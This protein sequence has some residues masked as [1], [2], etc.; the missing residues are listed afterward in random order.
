MLRPLFLENSLRVVLFVRLSSWEIF[1]LIRNIG[2]LASRS[3]YSEHVSSRSI[4]HPVPSSYDFPSDRMMAIYRRMQIPDSDKMIRWAKPLRTDRKIAARVKSPS[5]AGSLAA[6]FN[7]LLK[8]KDSAT[9][10][11]RSMDHC[12]SGRAL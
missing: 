2:V 3:N 6:P 11:E 7:E 12:A 8:W 9:S 10:S 5:L 4:L 1:A